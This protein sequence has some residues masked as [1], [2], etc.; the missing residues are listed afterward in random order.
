[1]VN[2]F[3]FNWKEQPDKNRHQATINMDG[4]NYALRVQKIE[5]NVWWWSVHNHDQEILMSSYT[6]SD[7]AATMDQAKS[8]S[9]NGFLYLYENSKL[10]KCQIA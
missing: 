4:L 5:N 3:T 1:M 9:Q 6:E 2:K 8:F 7:W 10:K